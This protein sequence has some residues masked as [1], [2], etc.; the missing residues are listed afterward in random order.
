MLGRRSL[1]NHDKEL[2]RFDASILHQISFDLTC[3][4]LSAESLDLF[5]IEACGF[6]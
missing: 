2:G 4:L 1:T 3:R 6:H 5:H